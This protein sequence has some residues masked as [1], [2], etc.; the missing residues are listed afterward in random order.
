MKKVLL[1]SVS[2]LA[3]SAGASFAQTSIPLVTSNVSAQAPTAVAAGNDF[4]IEQIG[5]NNNIGDATHSG[6]TQNVDSTT[7]SGNYSEIYQGWQGGPKYSNNA[8]AV[9]TQN[10]SG[11]G[12]NTARTVQYDADQTQAFPTQKIRVT[13][14]R[15]PRRSSPRAKTL[16]RLSRPVPTLWQ[17]SIKTRLVR[18]P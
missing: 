1:M 7:G 3:L 12:T 15:R 10:A 17:S 4:Y 14:L 13:T 5:N 18:S 16:R 9:V 11:G 2:A 8:T 6:V